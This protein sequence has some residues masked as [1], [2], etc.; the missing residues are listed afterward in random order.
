VT[1]TADET[2]VAS[3]APAPGRAGR[4]AAAA[5]LIAVLTVAARLAGFARTVVFVHLV[6]THELGTAYQSANTVPNI[7]FEIVAGGALA[8]LVVPMLAGA[9]SRGDRATVAATTSALLTWVLSLL[10][11][12]AV[13]VGL[14]AGPIARLLLDRGADARSVAVAAD[15]LRVFAPQL[16]LY[17]LGIVLTGV[18]QAHRRFA[19]P[20]LAPLLSSVTV[21]AAYATFAA[22]AGRRPEIAQ[23]S[24]T[25]VLVLSVGTTLGVV[26]LSLCLLIPL[27]SL[28]LRLRPTYA[29][30]PE[31]AVVV[32]RLAVAGAV[33]VAA[34]QLTV[35]LTIVLANRAGLTNLVLFTVA[36]TIY[37]LP[38]AVLA[39]PIAT[40]AYP[41]LA[42][43]AANGDHDRFASTLAGAT[44][45]L[46]L[47]GCLG[48]AGLAALATPLAYALASTS[49]PR[50]VAAGIA[51]LAPGLVG[52]ALFA[53]LSRALYARGDTRL[54]ALATVIG[55]GGVALASIA[56]SAALPRAD[57]V[58]ALALANSAGMLLL[59]AV[60]LAIVARRAGRAALAGLGRTLAASVT[61]ALLA[62]AAGIGARQVVESGATPG[63]A[64]ALGQGMLSGSVVAV[65]FVGVVY[66]LDRRDVRPL[67]A[68]TVR[69]ASRLARRR[70]AAGPP[71]DDHGAGRS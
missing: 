47:L 57:R 16:P 34:Q 71:A 19:W 58:T 28:R 33:T 31:S 20:V 13:V 60:L 51:G 61:A 11:P 14:A 2:G 48:A 7:I 5:L 17:G 3:P 66:A 39:L 59:G 63:I 44:R 22:V 67:L 35:G 4:L 42:E 46:A 55:W 10:I 26:V 52:Y 29:F 64:G 53:L 56:L 68:A 27:R 70:G 25:G 62:A 8:S 38:W 18:L 9:V 65:A 69:R 36:Q 50:L 37:L 40:S 54:A 21:M 49:D 15:M 41:A 32:R 30:A 12:V 23:V 1:E 6:G 45:G 43:A 24:G